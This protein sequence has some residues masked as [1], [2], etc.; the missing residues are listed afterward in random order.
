MK[1]FDVKLYFDG[2]ETSDRGYLTDKEFDEW[3]DEKWKQFLN[4][5]G[6]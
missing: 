1:T 5:Y 4:K 2:V 6:Y 3:K